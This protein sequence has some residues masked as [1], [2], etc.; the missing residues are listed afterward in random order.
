MQGLANIATLTGVAYEVSTVQPMMDALVHEV[1]DRLE[2]APSSDPTRQLTSQQLSEIL[3]ACAHS[4][5]HPGDRL[6]DAVVKAV[7]LHEMGLQ[8]RYEAATT[9]P[10][11]VQ[12]RYSYGIALVCLYAV[13]H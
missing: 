2:A 1:A 3:Y 11:C 4:K 5:Y 12:K 7:Q 6:L 8:V 13:R 9:A 10:Q